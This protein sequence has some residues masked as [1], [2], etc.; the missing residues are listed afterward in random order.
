MNYYYTLESDI[1]NMKEYNS[2]I[3]F[4]EKVMILYESGDIKS[5]TIFS[6]KLAEQFK[7]RKGKVSKEQMKKMLLNNPSVFVKNTLGGI[8]SDLFESSNDIVQKDS[9]YEDRACRLYE[10]AYM[11][12]VFGFKKNVKRIDPMTIEYIAVKL[13][14]MRSNDD[15]LMLISYIYSKLDIIDYYLD[16]MNNPKTA[17]RYIIPHT[18]NELTNMKLQLEKLKESVVNKKIPEYRYSVRVDYPDGYEG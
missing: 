2:I 18:R 1:Q 12:E 7:E 14:S 15:K 6:I 11:T 8:V 3:T 17:N 5:D 10:N 9:I 4:T 13:D 16:L